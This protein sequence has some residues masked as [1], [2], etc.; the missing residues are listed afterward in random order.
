MNIQYERNGKMDQKGIE[1]DNLTIPHVYIKLF[2][3]VAQNSMKKVDFDI[4]I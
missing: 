1:G 3:C 4:V 2:F